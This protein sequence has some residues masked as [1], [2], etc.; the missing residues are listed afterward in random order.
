[1][2]E[3]LLAE[4][5]ERALLSESDWLGFAISMDQP[6]VLKY[7]L[8]RIGTLP[9]MDLC[10]QWPLFK[11]A[12]SHISLENFQFLINY[13]ASTSLQDPNG[14]TSSHILSQSHE[15]VSLEKLE[16]L[17][18]AN[19][20][21][22]QLNSQGITPLALAVRC[23]NNPAV[24][25]LLTSG[26]DSETPLVGQQTALHHAS[27][28]RNTEAV[29]L[30]LEHGCTPHPEDSDGSRPI[31]IA[32]ACGYTE[33]ADL[34]QSAANE[35]YHNP[36]SEISQ[37]SEVAEMPDSLQDRHGKLPL[38]TIEAPSI[39][40][41]RPPILKRKNSENNPEAS[42]ANPEKRPRANPA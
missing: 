32:L 37:G 15:L 40:S 30:L 42:T 10:R 12:K 18:V 3:L 35:D 14:N 36:P 22:N 16:C 26:A 1:M 17:I 9:N 41:D 39:E 21:L 20:D 4:S 5:Y 7:L 34:I 38:R 33:L 31:D 23:K 25:L 19:A 8:E 28:V 13:G 11:L 6:I 2:T 29:Q 24:E 27:L